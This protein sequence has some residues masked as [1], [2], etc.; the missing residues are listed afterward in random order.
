M[1]DINKTITTA[2]QKL[3]GKIDNL[4]K[5]QKE[6]LSNIDS[7][8]ARFT[9]IVNDVMFLKTQADIISRWRK[10]K[11]GENLSSTETWYELTKN[12]NEYFAEEM[13]AKR[14][15]LIN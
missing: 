6:I 14:S 5:G 7:L 9:H 8:D 1:T 11:D 2:L 15:G 3:S 4:Q 13:R 12:L 10:A